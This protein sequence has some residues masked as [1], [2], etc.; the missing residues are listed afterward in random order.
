MT[1]LKFYKKKYYE[2]SPKDDKDHYVN[3]SLNDSLEVKYVHNV[4]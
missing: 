4:G 3:C 2:K 1:N